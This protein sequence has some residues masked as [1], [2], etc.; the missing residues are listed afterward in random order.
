M[1]Q[2]PRPRYRVGGA[3]KAPLSLSEALVVFALSALGLAW[4]VG[5][6]VLALRVFG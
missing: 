2:E 4:I 5:G 3:P 1:L 6:A